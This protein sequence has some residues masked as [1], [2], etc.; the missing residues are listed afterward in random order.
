MG[1]HYA[2]V[3]VPFRQAQP[4]YQRRWR[5]GQRLREIRDESSRL[6]GAL[7]ARLRAM[8]SHAESLTQ[9]AIGAVQTGVLAGEKLLRAVTLVRTTIA[10]LEQL[11][12][13]TAELGQLAL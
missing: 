2:D 4:D 12:A 8:V 13:S 9:R 10:L 5:W 1:S 11:D 6:G 7:L 3:V